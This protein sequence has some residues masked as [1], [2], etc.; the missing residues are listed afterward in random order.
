MA[1][2]TDEGRAGTLSP[3][4]P[5]NELSKMKKKGGRIRWKTKLRLLGFY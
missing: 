2:P 5:H 1:S 4:H 3:T